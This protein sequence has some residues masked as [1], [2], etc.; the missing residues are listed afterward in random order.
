MTMTTEL[1]QWLSDTCRKER[2]SLRRAAAKTGL[3]HATIADILNG[4]QVT[5][6]TIKKLAAAFGNGGENQR[7]AL[8]DKLLILAG[9][10]SP[11]HNGDLSEPMARLLDQVQLLN[12]PELKVITRFA[13]FLMELKKTEHA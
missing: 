3:S 9:Y 11:R 13:D 8:E 2:L 7:L 5:A 12:E 6:D 1:G 4:G 10:R